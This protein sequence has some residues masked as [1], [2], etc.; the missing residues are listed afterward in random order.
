MSSSPWYLDYFE[1]QML[2]TTDRH[3]GSGKGTECEPYI[4]MSG[5]CVELFHTTILEFLNAYREFW[6]DVETDA[7]EVYFLIAPFNYDLWFLYVK[8]LKKSVKLTLYMTEK[9]ARSSDPIYVIFKAVKIVEEK[10]IPPEF[11]CPITCEVMKE[12]IILEDGFTYEYSAI[13]KWLKKSVLSPMTNLN[14]SPPIVMIPNRSLKSMI[15]KF[16][17]SFRPQTN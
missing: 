8:T 3:I 11:L 7:K 1:E 15:E 17:E 13:S 12:P 4:I 2:Q 14:L 9:E 10:T 6:R 16:N 5:L